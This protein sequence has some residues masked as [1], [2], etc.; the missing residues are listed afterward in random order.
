MSK[1]QIFLT[2]ILKLILNFPHKKRE[3]SSFFSVSFIRIVYI[4]LAK[5]DTFSRW[6]LVSPPVICFSHIYMLHFPCWINDARSM[7]YLDAG[8]SH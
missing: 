1:E 8:K 5:K 4:F 6:A 2:K 7:T 3:G